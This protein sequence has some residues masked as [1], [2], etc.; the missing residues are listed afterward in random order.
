MSQSRGTE[1][2]SRDRITGPPTPTWWSLTLFILL[3]FVGATVSLFVPDQTPIQQFYFRIIVALG[4]AGIASI[5][6][7]YFE[8]EVRIARILIRSAGAIGIFVLVYFINPAQLREKTEGDTLKVPNIIGT[9]EYTCTAT[10]EVF[11]HGGI[12]H[13]G[14]CEFSTERREWGM[15]IIVHGERQWT[16]H[17]LEDDKTPLGVESRWSSEK[18]F[19]TGQ[20]S[21]QY[22]YQTI[23]QEGIQYGQSRFTII[24]R[25]DSPERLEG[26]FERRPSNRSIIGTVVMTRPVT[27]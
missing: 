22:E 4:A 20:N 3:C 26:T 11:P 24:I 15:E 13:G 8:I 19:F 23:E 16:R 18:G 21:F 6:P 1:K 14:V 9:W 12:Q 5:I 10:G 25:E 27:P 17:S 2:D 7:G